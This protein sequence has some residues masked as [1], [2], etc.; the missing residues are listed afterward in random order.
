MSAPPIPRIGL[1]TL[2]PELLIQISDYVT[3]NPEGRIVENSQLPLATCSRRT[4]E[5]FAERLTKHRAFLR[6]RSLVIDPPAKP[7]IGSFQ[8]SLDLVKFLH[9]VPLAANYIHTLEFAAELEVITYQNDIRSPVACLDPAT[10]EIARFAVEK[11]QPLVDTIAQG[12]PQLTVE[13]LYSDLLESGGL[14][15]LACLLP[16]LRQLRIVHADDAWLGTLGSVTMAAY[17]NG[18]LQF[19]GEKEAAVVPLRRLKKAV[20]DN[21][22]AGQRSLSAAWLPFLHLPEPPVLE[23]DRLRMEHLRRLIIGL[24]S[25]HT[26]VV[27]ECCCNEDVLARLAE[28]N[29]KRLRIVCKTCFPDGKLNE[30]GLVKY[31]RLLRSTLLDAR[32]DGE[33]VWLSVSLRPRDHGIILE[34]KMSA[35]LMKV[36][37][38]AEA[39]QHQLDGK[40]EV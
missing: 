3:T 29:P 11:L 23:V 5:V 10:L 22:P 17:S 12:T 21:L 9:H 20:F 18:H 6:Y 19:C 37:E 32:M 26:L 13:S 24:Q 1:T 35:K 31:N 8:L 39:Y 36:E 40:F 2:P 38:L 16:S 27:R 30:G 7:A 4:L 28:V 34:R 14:S 15:V 33:L 25:L